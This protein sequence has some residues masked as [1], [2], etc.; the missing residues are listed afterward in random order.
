MSHLGRQEGD[1]LVVDL[2][3]QTIE[4]WAALW[5]ALAKPCGLPEWF[6]RNLD[7]WWDTVDTGAIS[8]VIDEHPKVLVLVAPRGMFAPGNREGAAFAEVTNE[9]AYAALEV[10]PVPQS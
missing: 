4:S 1:P 5:D 6:G 9:S 10:R 8:D 7:A 3:D 2:S